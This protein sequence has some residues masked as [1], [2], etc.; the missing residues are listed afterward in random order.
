MLTATIGL[1]RDLGYAQGKVV[2]GG[3]AVNGA[4]ALRGLPEDYDAW[5]R[6]GCARSCLCFRSRLSSRIA[7]DAG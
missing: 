4:L 2:G 6:A 1:G 5:Q 7:S 3:S